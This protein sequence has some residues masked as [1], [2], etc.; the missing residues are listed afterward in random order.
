MIKNSLVLQ[1]VKQLYYS[2][3]TTDIVVQQALYI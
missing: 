1:L 3:N 2:Y